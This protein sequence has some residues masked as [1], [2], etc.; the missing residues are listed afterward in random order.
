MM[1]YVIAN[2]IVHDFYSW[3]L[4]SSLNKSVSLVGAFD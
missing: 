2:N 1:F 4:F 3:A